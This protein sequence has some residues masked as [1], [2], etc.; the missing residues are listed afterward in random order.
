[1]CYIGSAF[2]TAC[3]LLHFPFPHFQSPLATPLTNG[4]F[5]PSRIY[6]RIRFRKKNRV[7][8]CRLCHCCW[9]VCAAIARQA[10]EAGRRVSRAKEWAELQART[11]GRYGN[12][13]NSIIYERINGNGELTET[14]NVIFYLS[15][16]VLTEF[17]RMNVIFTETNTT[18]DTATDT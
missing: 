5:P 14:E 17:L 9:G 3:L 4:R 6:W 13:Q 18:T 1:M 15:Y 12:K 10:Q 11:N 2:R 7:R 16:G 8:T